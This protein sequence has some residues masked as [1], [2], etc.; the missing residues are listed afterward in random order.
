MCRGKPGTQP[1]PGTFR[2][3]I[4]LGVAR[5]DMEAR[6]WGWRL[7]TEGGRC[8][9]QD[10][11][12]EFRLLPKSKK[13]ACSA[14]R[15]HPSHLW[16]QSRGVSLKWGNPLDG[17]CPEEEAAEEGC[18]GFEL[19]GKRQAG[20]AGR[21]QV[22]RGGRVEGGD[23]EHPLVEWMDG[24]LTEAGNTDPRWQRNTVS[25]QCRKGIIIH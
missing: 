19:F 1:R 11:T 18:S 2:E 20:R 14:A 7:E 8:V 6:R 10:H 21:L 9:L 25:A 23:S 17:A 3:E 16:G 13:R 12:E 22:G 24:P 5:G 15:G 4:S